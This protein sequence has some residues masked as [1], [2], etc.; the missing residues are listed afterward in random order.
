VGDPGWASFPPE[1][2]KEAVMNRAGFR[3][4]GPVLALTAAA[5][6]LVPSGSVQASSNSTAAATTIQ[7]ASATL[8]QDFR[9]TLTAVRGPSDGGAPAATVEIAAYER[10]D[11]NDGWRLLGQQTV[12][13]ANNWLW[14]VVTGPQAICRFSTS[15]NSPY[16]IEVRLLVSSSIGCSEATYNFH[17]DKY[18]LLVGG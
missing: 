14:N 5:A 2:I 15:D 12:G 4:A 8:G 11:G 18:G 1:K 7:I 3:V 13:Q 9:A 10:S 17:V 16:P 6:T